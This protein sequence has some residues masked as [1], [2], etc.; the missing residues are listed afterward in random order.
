MPVKKTTTKKTA[1][2]KSTNKAVKKPATKKVTKKPISATKPAVTKKVDVIVETKKT[3]KGDCSMK[4]CG[5]FMK[6]LFII[7]LL[8]NLLFA[9]LNFAKKDSAIAIEEM[10][11]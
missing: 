2:A 5:G 6:A 11:V 7:L 1:T 8:L 3:N 4:K 9:V 10:K